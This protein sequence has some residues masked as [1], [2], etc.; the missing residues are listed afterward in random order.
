MRSIS[1]WFDAGGPGPPSMR[2]RTYRIVIVTKLAKS[3]PAGLYVGRRSTL[4]AL[5]HDRPPPRVARGGLDGDLAA[6]RHP[7]DAESLGA[8]V[9]TL[10]NVFD[11]G[12]SVLLK[13]HRQARR[14]A[15]AD[16]VAVEI[17]DQNAV[18]P[19]GQ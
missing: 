14:P 11:R 17:E 5:E 16:T 13:A 18:T 1:S 6:E 2:P 12:V 8:D 10:T 7:D 19:A 15:V 4:H 3:G 9:A